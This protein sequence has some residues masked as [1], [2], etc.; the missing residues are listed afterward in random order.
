MTIVVGYVPKPEG[1][2]ALRRAAEEARL[3]GERLVVVSSLRAVRDTG[4]DAD[5]Q[6]EQELLTVRD[7][8]EAAGIEHEVRQLVRGQEPSEDLI[9]IA[10]EVH[11]DVI[12]IGLRRRSPVGKLILGSNAQRILLDAPC[13]V[14]AVKADEDDR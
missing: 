7:A 1:R 4:A 6:Y 2:A 9:A 14:L 10:E 5:N 12:V 3:R 13:P 8:L 11:A